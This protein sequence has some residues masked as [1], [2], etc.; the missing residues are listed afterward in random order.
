MKITGPGSAS[1]TG[2]ASALADV[3]RVGGKDFAAAIDKS[4]AATAP[5]AATRPGTAAAGGLV[6]DISAELKAGQITP[7]TAIDRVVERILD[8]QV[9]ANAPAAVRETVGAALRDA[10]ESDPLLAEKIR[11][12]SA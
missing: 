1:P 8:K 3:P 6:G 9:G 5:E 2:G 12:L 7:Q 4:A 11:S 10:L